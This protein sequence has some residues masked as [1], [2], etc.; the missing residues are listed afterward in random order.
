MARSFSRIS[1]QQVETLYPKGGGYD[2]EILVY[3]DLNSRK[4]DFVGQA[5]AIKEAVAAS[6]TFNRATRL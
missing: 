1:R 5:R 2:P 4:R 6:P 3:D